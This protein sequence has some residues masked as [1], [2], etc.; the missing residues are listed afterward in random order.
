MGRIQVVIKHRFM[1][2]HL[3]FKDAMEYL[4]LTQGHGV[5]FLANYV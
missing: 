3:V 5:G 4:E 2:H 1:L